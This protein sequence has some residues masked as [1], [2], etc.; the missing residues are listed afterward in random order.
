VFISQSGMVQRTG[1]KGISS[2]G[3]PA[4]GVRLMNLRDDDTVSAVAL[5]MESEADTAA[6]VAGD[7]PLPEMPPEP[8]GPEGNGKA[9][10]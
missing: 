4:Q 1:V 6:P 9:T 2:Q 5:V 8:E 7:E 10:D 3:R